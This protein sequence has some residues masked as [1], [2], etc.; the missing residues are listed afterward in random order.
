MNEDAPVGDC[1]QVF[2][3]GKFEGGCLIDENSRNA[4]G[5]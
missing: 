4:L 3:Y 1:L 5:L 2:F